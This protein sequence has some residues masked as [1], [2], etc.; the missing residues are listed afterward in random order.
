MSFNLLD[1]VKG[2]IS[3]ELVG[4]AAS[5]LGESESSVTKAMS[6]ILPSVLGGLVSKAT[7]GGDGAS[8]ILDMAKGAAS[9]GILGNLGNLFGGGGNSSLLSSGA[10]MLSGLFGDKIGGI[11][12]LIS[13][14]AGIKQSSASSL[15]SMAAPAAL[16]FL[17]KHAS[18]NNLNASGLTSLLASQKDSIMKALPSGLGN[19]TSMLGLGSVAGAVSSAT[20]HAKEATSYA[21]EKASSGTKW[22]WPLL[23]LLLGGGLLYYFSKGCGGAKT[24]EAPAADTTTVKT[25]VTPAP[26]PEPAAPAPFRVKLPNG[27]ELDAKQGGIE[28]Q[29]VT[30][31]SG[32]WKG[33]GADSLKKIWFNFDNLNFDLG[34]STL[35]PDSEKQLDNIA[36][37]LKAFPDA[38]VKIGGYTDAAGNAASNLKLSGERANAA[39]AGLAK[40]GVGAQVTDAEGYGSKFAKFPATAPDSDRANDRHV[41]LSVRQ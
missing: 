4:K 6:G 27:K 12:S 16:G 19:L 13:N 29:L 37:I 17:G 24:E 41:S 35:L 25:E 33:L 7:S 10:T 40:R 1:S 20:S 15:M 36:E 18:D 32:N 8:S 21:T 28:D 23:L 2:L 14:F 34:K 11:A 38:K 26:T 31:L 5:S 30:F 9:S 39:K 22:L 3:N